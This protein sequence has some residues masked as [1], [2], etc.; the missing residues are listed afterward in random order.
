MA[1]SASLASRTMCSMLVP[2]STCDYCP[3]S[4]LHWTSMS[5]SETM[6]WAMQTKREGKK[7]HWDSRH[8]RHQVAAPPMHC[9]FTHTHAHPT[10]FYI[11]L[12]SYMKALI[13]KQQWSLTQE[14]AH[15]SACKV[16][17]N[18]H[19]DYAKDWNLQRAV[20]PNIHQFNQVKLET[21]KHLPI[22][23]MCRSRG[24]KLMAR[25][26]QQSSKHGIAYTTINSCN[27]CGGKYQFPRC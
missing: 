3:A 17:S 25:K 18:H 6:L 1:G 26:K 19:E 24:T 27:F 10:M 9:Y 2:P 8:K 14:M 21:R 4:L 12:V 23:M 15:S 11:H 5:S 22:Q 7:G 20:S 13:G 16:W